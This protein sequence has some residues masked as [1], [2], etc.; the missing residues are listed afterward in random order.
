MITISPKEYVYELPFCIIVV[1]EPQTVNVGTI[2]VVAV[3][4]V[5][6]DMFWAV[7]RATRPNRGRTR[8]VERS[9]LDWM[10]RECAE[11]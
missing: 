1:A 4:A 2:M 6:T 3:A 11:K 7:E 10:C 8:R 5:V 9:I